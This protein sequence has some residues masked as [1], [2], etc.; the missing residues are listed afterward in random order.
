MSEQSAAM[1][2]AY[3][4]LFHET[5][6]PITLADSRTVFART[7]DITGSKAG[8]QAIS[9]V[10]FGPFIASTAPRQ[11]QF[12]VVDF[13]GQPLL[14]EGEILV[15]NGLNYLVTVVDY[16]NMDNETTVIY[17]NALRFIWQTLPA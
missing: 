2:D 1:A 8:E 10:T 15:R 13:E 4:Y 17:A 5:G 6:E 14:Q 11:F 12:S 3:T 9:S 7:V 16:V